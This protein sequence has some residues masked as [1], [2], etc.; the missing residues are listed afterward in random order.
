MSPGYESPEAFRMALTERL[1]AKAARRGVPIETLRTKV[2]I[3]RLLARL[4]HDERAPWSLKG[5]YSF[6][7]RYRPD[8]RTTLDIAISGCRM[9]RAQTS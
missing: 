1:R 5:G 7:L 4:I 2:F 9:L 8:A 6:E 3:E